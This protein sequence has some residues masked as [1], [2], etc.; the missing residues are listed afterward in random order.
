MTNRDDALKRYA[1]FAALRVTAYIFLALVLVF[2]YTPIAIAADGDGGT[3]G[4][5][6]E[7][8]Q[9]EEPP[10]VAD[11]SQLNIAIGNAQAAA[12]SYPVIDADPADVDAGVQYV[13]SYTLGALQ[14]AIGTAQSVAANGSATQDE[15]N[16]QTNA[17]SYATSTFYANVLTGSKTVA[18]EPSVTITGISIYLKDTDDCLGTNLGDYTQVYES[19]RDKA[20][21]TQKGG[22]L[23]FDY[24]SL[25]SNGDSSARSDGTA[26]WWSSDPSIASFNSYRLE[27]HKDGTVKIRAIVDSD[28]TGG[29]ELYAEATIQIAGQEDSL[30]IDSIR[31]ISPD[32][33]DVTDGLYQMEEKLSTA[34]AQFMAEV[35]VVDPST[36]DT[37][38]YKTDGRLSQQVPDLGD[39]TWTV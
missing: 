27:P 37:T 30:Y 9:P 13:T 23:E 3:R 34:Q 4:G 21:I 10:A 20:R 17:V 38:T 8:G 11:F 1:L 33:E 7:P 19:V 22:Y 28:K 25:W 32:G 31:I 16:N 26:T 29:A 12:G 36:G 15:V 35:D 18:P 6:T 14:S 5:T 2:G 39:L 24:V